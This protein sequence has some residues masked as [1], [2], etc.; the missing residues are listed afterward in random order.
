MKIIV[1][2]AGKSSRFPNMRPK[3]MLTH[4]DG[5]MMVKKAI[6]SIRGVSLKDVIIT[7][8]KEHEE[9]YDIVRG[10]KENIGDDITIIILDEPTKSQSETV[11]ETLKK[12]KIT[13][14][15]IVKDSDN[16]FS[17]E[18]AEEKFNYICYSNLQEYTEINPSNKSYIVMND[19]GIITEI[20][21][22]KIVSQTFN[23]GGYYFTNA[24]QF[25]ETY[26]LLANKFADKELYLSSIVEHMLLNKTGVFFGKKIEN[27]FDWGTLQDWQKYRAKFKTYFFDL[28]GVLFKNGAQYFTPRWDNAPFIDE[29]LKLL[30]ELSINPYVQIF[31][32]SSRPE[33]YRNML[34]KKF[35]EEGIKYDGMLLGCRHAK[36]IIVND[37]SD[38]NVYPVC[39]AINLP[40]DSTELKK[41]IS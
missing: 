39:E 32:V 34:E 36:R 14:N 24:S 30:K 3:W 23:V 8:L 11:Y 5:D 19:Q 41:Y 22:K 26:E 28:D 33:K 15:F 25:I 12:A 27:Y 6:E 4:P 37:F 38:T 10:L 40:R 1:P 16:I 21:E 35:K 2:C 13:G 29:N 18:N 9:K 7:I 17:L 20:V 31:F